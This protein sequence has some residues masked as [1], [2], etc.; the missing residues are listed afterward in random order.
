MDA[1]SSRAPRVRTPNRERVQLVT[2][3]SP[4]PWISCHPH[5]VTPTSESAT[6]E[7]IPPRQ[8]WRS[9]GRAEDARPTS[10]GVCNNSSEIPA[11]ASCGAANTFGDT[12]ME[13]PKG[14]H[15]RVR[16]RRTDGASATQPSDSCID[17]AFATAKSRSRP[18]LVFDRRLAQ[19][20]KSC[21]AFARRSSLFIGAELQCPALAQAA[22]Q[23][24]LALKGISAIQ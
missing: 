20:C 1:G 2:S 17:L 19:A 9:E 6:S 16:G 15:G 12:Q 21:N 5:G 3:Y 11:G 23:Q 4:R 7:S 14:A 18:A 10:E 13:Q 24:A 22:S 8:D